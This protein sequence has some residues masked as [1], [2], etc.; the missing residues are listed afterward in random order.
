MKTAFQKMHEKLAMIKHNSADLSVM[1]AKHTHG[2]G[3]GL[4]L[5]VNG[6]TPAA[7]LMNL[8]ELEHWLPDHDTSDKLNEFSQE[9]LK[10]DPRRTP[11]EFNEYGPEGMEAAFQV[12]T[13]PIKFN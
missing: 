1:V 12:M 10:K 3:W 4:F 6:S 9:W 2:Q 5:C 13:A 8:D 7:R 11:A